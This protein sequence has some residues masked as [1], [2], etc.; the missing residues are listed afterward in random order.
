MRRNWTHKNLSD[1][2]KRGMKIS[3]QPISNNRVIIPRQDSK[4]VQWMHWN[5]MYFCNEHALQLEKEYRFDE[6]RF[7]RFDFAIPALKIAIEFEG[8]FKGTSR[9]TT[10]TGFLGDVEKYNQA[11]RLGWNLQR[12]TADTYRNVLQ[13]LRKIIN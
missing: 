4:E 8:I 5:L 13:D 1:L 3:V 10:V 7:W 6:K 12:Y 11:A 2:A 9:H